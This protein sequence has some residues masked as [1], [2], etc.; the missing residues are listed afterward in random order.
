[1]KKYIKT[2]KAIYFIE[3]P[4]KISDA[5]ID[6][7]YVILDNILYKQNAAKNQE[8][9]TPYGN[10]LKVSANISDFIIPMETL[11]EH[12]PILQFEKYN[13]AQ[14]IKETSI[15][16]AVGE[17]ILFG[18]ILALYDKNEHGDFIRYEIK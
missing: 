4:P 3:M 7:E 10:I 13:F 16:T 12:K 18:D 1:M 14:I 9:L 5:T 8:R 11:I 6:D 17:I 2:S 15:V